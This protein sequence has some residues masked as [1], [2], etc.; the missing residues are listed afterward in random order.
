M[1]SAVAP[2]PFPVH[3]FVLLSSGCGGVSPSFNCLRCASVDLFVVLLPLIQ[4]TKKKKL[5]PDRN[6]TKNPKPS[7]NPERKGFS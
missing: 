3:V 2:S 6:T 5:K 4:S 1:K 7:N